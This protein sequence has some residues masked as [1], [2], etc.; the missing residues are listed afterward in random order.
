M[1]VDMKNATAQC[2]NTT[3]DL[4]IDET[5]L[6]GRRLVKSVKHA[7]SFEKRISRLVCGVSDRNFTYIVTAK[8]CCK[9]TYASENVLMDEFADIALISL[10]NN[11]MSSSISFLVLDDAMVQVEIGDK[12]MSLLR[13]AALQDQ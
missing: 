4:I 12:L 10:R 3:E 6:Y 9:P 11:T 1:S 8:H 7:I 13:N 5:H 2:F